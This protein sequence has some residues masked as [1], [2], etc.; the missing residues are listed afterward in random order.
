MLPELFKRFAEMHFCSIDVPMLAIHYR[1]QRA[2]HV[3]N[4]W[5]CF[6]CITEEWKRFLQET[7]GPVM[8]VLRLRHQRGDI[9]DD[10][11]R[12]GLVKRPQESDR[13][14]KAVVRLI[15]LTMR[16]C[17]EPAGRHR[18][19]S[20]PNRGFSAESQR[21]FHQSAPLAQITAEKPE[22]A[23]RENEALGDLCL[24]LVNR[25][26][27]RQAEIAVLGIDAGEPSSICRSEEFEI[28]LLFG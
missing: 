27:K 7:L 9:Q 11:D 21:P 4:E 18:Q 26:F 6:A 17:K 22:T 15:E 23:E 14:R 10:G 8:L 28:G 19:S 3:R 16:P 13:L 25:P 20:D 12:H 24:G 1:P 2:E 5:C